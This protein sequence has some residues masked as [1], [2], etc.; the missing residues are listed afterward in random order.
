MPL[1]LYLKKKNFQ[2][3]II[4]CNIITWTV[5]VHLYKVYRFANFFIQNKIILDKLI[6]KSQLTK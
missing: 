3:F 4:N 1:E 5:F 6:K 2:I